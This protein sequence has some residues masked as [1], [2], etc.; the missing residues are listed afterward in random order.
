MTIQLQILG[1]PVFLMHKHDKRK[2]RPHRIEPQTLDMFERARVSHHPVTKYTTSLAAA[3]R[4]GKKTRDLDFQL[5]W[6]LGVVSPGTEVQVLT[7]VAS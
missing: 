1:R 4:S 7:G 2:L 5:R 3:L 6:E